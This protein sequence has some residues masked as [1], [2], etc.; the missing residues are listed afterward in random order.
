MAGGE[1]GGEGGGEEVEFPGKEVVGAL[2]ENEAVFAGEGFHEGFDGWG[3]AELI[4]L[5]VKE[6]LGL[7]AGLEVGE[8]GIVD[9]SAEA[10][11][12][13][14]TRIFAADAQTD[15][16]AKAE[17]GEEK[18]QAGKFAG[19]KVECGAN[20]IAL[21]AAAI[22]LAFAQARAAKI[23][24]QDRQA[25][26]VERLSHLID[27]FVVQGAAEERMGVAHDSGER[28]MSRRARGPQ[29]GF[30]TADRP[31]EEESAVIMVAHREF[32]AQRS[33]EF[34]ANS[35]QARDGHGD[36]VRAR[37]GVDANDEGA[38][39]AAR[40]PARRQSS[41]AKRHV[42][43]V[44]GLVEAGGKKAHSVEGEIERHGL[45]VPG[46]IGEADANG[47]GNGLARAGAVIGLFAQAV[48][49]CR[50]PPRG[51]KLN[52][53][54][55]VAVIGG[56]FADHAR[57]EFRGVVGEGGVVRKGDPEGGAGGMGVRA[58]DEHAVARNVARPA[59]V[60]GLFERPG[61]AETD[62]QG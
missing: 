27:D 46:N 23:E 14:D 43:V 55:P 54:A 60:D 7:G 38:R 49:A 33:R 5:A 12:L 16:A 62:G 29:D 28:R 44:A 40:G 35:G 31:I 41:A 21:A 15:P 56:F 39:F 47:N 61:P 13:G 51:D 18:R 4:A 20:V 10:D 8:I 52:A 1:P 11:K 32:D 45:L 26:T 57:G 22:V 9:G 48:A 19:E 36:L 37:I 3:V 17:S 42:Q 25:E 6:E 2:D 24:A 53:Q 58:V 34:N 30:E 59:Y 50:R